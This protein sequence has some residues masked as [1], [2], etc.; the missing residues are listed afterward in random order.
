M[1]T[2]NYKKIISSSIPI[3]AIMLIGYFFVNSTLN[4]ENP[5]EISSRIGSIGIN[6]QDDSI[7]ERLGYYSDAV[8]SIMQYP[9]LGI[10]V[11]NWKIKSIEYAGNTVSGYTVPYHAHNDFL[12]ITAEIGIIGGLLYLMIYLIPIYR[13]LIELNLRVLDNLNLVYLLIISA[14]FIDS[15]LNFPIARPVNHIYLIFTLVAFL[16]TYKSNFN[17]EST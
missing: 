10:G 11:G 4:T 12:Q 7:N 14:V 8:K 5:D 6:T 3:I 17:N 1:M 15:M 13:I 16:Q 2:F 9:I